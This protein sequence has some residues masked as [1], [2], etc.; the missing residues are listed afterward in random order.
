MC[1]HLCVVLD[2]ADDEE[3]GVAAVLADPELTAV[4]AAPDDDVAEDVC[5][6]AALA[7][8]MLPPNPTPS[9]P[10]PI[11]VPR[12]ILPIR[13]LTMPPPCD[14]VSVLRTGHP[15]GLRTLCGDAL[16]TV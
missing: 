12:M 9:A 4:V 8:A 15:R 14:R 7:T 1:A 5:V 11:A 16:P 13:V 10:A 6:V 3:E 2:E